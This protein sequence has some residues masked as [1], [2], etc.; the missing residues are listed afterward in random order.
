MVFV[1]IDVMVTYNDELMLLL[2][3]N[4]EFFRIRVLLTANTGGETT[5]IS[6]AKMFIYL[7]PEDLGQNRKGS[8]GNH[9]NENDALEM[10]ST[11][12]IHC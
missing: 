6:F 1:I 7:K 8:E 2:A 4:S 3:S 5:I 10:Y 12:N 9:R 11:L